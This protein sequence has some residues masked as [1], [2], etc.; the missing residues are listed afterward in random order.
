M[1][2]ALVKGAI[3]EGAITGDSVSVFDV[4]DSASNKLGNEIGATVTSSHDDLINKSE[5]VLLCVK[6]QDTL[7]MIGALQAPD[8]SKLF[9][10][11]AAGLQLLDLEKCI[12]LENF[13]RKR[14][15]E[16]LNF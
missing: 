10:S 4:I 1:G 8:Q 2:S 11:I 3:K 7:K 15:P 9:I 16:N 12:A 13:P 5:V 14:A 6:P